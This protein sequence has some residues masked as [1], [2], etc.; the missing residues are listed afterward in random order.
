MRRS[1]ILEK[2]AVRLLDYVKRGDLFQILH[3]DVSLHKTKLNFNVLVRFGALI[4][5]YVPEQGS[6]I[7][8]LLAESHATGIRVLVHISFLVS[9]KPAKEAEHAYSS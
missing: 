7:M 9:C 6:W 8:C 4:F 2:W 5:L 3:Y 1:S